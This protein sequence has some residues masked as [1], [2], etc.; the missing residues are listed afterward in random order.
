MVSRG[1]IRSGVPLTWVHVG[2]TARPFVVLK[3]LPLLWPT[4]MRLEL[5]G[6]T[7]IALI[8]EL[9][10]VGALIEAHDGPVDAVFG[11]DASSV[12]HRDQPPPSNRV[13]EFGSSMKGAM[14]FAL[15]ARLPPEH[16]SGIE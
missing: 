11:V 15:P 10:E 4:Q 1:T 14:K 6:A 9:V 7:A 5:P 2:A 16:A 13:G 3:M 12:R 8:G